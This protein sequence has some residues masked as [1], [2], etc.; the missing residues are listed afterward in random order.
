MKNKFWLVV[1]DDTREMK[2]YSQLSAERY[3]E[4]LR[5]LFPGKE[6][7]ILGHSE[8]VGPIRATREN[9]KP[10]TI[11][12]NAAGTRVVKILASSDDYV[13]SQ[14]IATSVIQ[15][16]AESISRFLKED[17]WYQVQPI[18]EPTT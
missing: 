11:W 18:K 8:S 2:H 13:Q 1:G 16:S 10:G 4:R 14:R 5:E 3:A 15:F 12:Q 9:L 6:F 7:H 17:I